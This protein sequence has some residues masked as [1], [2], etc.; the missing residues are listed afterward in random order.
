MILNP[1]MVHQ[2]GTAGGA[3]VTVTY[4]HHV[5]R[6][7]GTDRW[8]YRVVCEMCGDVHTTRA[9]QDSLELAAAKAGFHA[10]LCTL[11]PTYRMAVA[12]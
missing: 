3:L 12:A 7:A 11:A 8:L 10:G 9:E 6:L 2:T 5:D 1:N 4:E